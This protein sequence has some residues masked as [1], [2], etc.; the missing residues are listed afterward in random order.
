M[1][2]CVP[3]RSWKL[4]AES[5]CSGCWSYV[6]VEGEGFGVGV[7][8]LGIAFQGERDGGQAFAFGLFAAGGA[9]AVDVQ[10][11]RTATSS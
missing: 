5:G 6:H 4:A 7:V 9:S 3:W 10:G 1:A 11:R 8:V 2:L